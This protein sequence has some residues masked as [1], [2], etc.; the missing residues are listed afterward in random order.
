[1]FIRSKVPRIKCLSFLINCNREH[2]ALLTLVISEHCCTRNCITMICLNHY[3]RSHIAGSPTKRIQSLNR[4]FLK[5][6]MA[7]FFCGILKL[8][9]AHNFFLDMEIHQFRGILLLRHQQTMLQKD[10][11]GMHCRKITPL[12]FHNVI[13]QQRLYKFSTL[14]NCNLNKE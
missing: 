2:M 1:M 13:W 4:L 5:T 3:L 14:A 11:G 9:A 6:L 12:F 7:F 10:D 8:Y